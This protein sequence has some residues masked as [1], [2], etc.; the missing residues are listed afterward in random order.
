MLPYASFKEN[1]GLDLQLG[2]CKLYIKD[3]C[4]I[5]A[6]ALVTDIINDEP[7]LS[8]ILEMQLHEDQSK[9]V[10]QVQGIPCVGVSARLPS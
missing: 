6:R 7:P 2:K 5:D 9:N 1:C 8:A 4:L 3:M 10:I